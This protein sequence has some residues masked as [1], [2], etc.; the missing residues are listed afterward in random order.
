MGKQG[1]FATSISMSTL[2][3]RAGVRPAVI[4]LL[5]VSV[6]LPGCSGSSIIPSAVTPKNLTL[7]FSGLTANAGPITIYTESGFSVSAS[8][9]IWV[10]STTY[11]SPAPFIQFRAAA[12]TVTGQVQVFAPG[13]ATFSFK[14]VDL[15]SSTT[16]IPYTITGLR[17]EIAVFTVSDTVPNTFGNFKTV[18]NSHGTDV[19]DLLIIRLS[20]PAAACCSNPMGLDNI[21][22]AQ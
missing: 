7:T 9:D 1:V 4:A 17:N 11:G 12:T 21:S 19:I 15:Y 13:N 2:P 22:L 20:N 6:G 5:L 10:A 18:V 14:S 8:P 3:R 16:P